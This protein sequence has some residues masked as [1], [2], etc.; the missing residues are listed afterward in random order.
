[1]TN[2]LEGPDSKDVQQL[3][4]NNSNKA[5]GGRLGY[6]CLPGLEIGGSYSRQKYDED[7]QL[8]IDF[9]GADIQFK[10][11]N[12]E[13]RGEYIVS[14]VD[15]A[16]VDGGNFDRNG[17]YLQASYKY[18]FDLNYVKSL[19]GVI[20][21][22]S[23]DDSNSINREEENRTSIGVNYFP[24]EH[25]TIKFEYEFDQESGQELYGKS[26]VQAIFKW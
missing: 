9:L 14:N 12:L 8:D 26:F 11:G 16:T 3:W 17:Y 6:E 7:N 2:G 24:I 4:D 18:P 1:M 10:R 19:E 5:I 25:V 22:A 15:R 23:L 20:R 21:F 13:L